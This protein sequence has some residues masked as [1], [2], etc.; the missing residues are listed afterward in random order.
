MVCGVQDGDES[1]SDSRDRAKLTLEW[2]SHEMEGVAC[3]LTS[4]GFA[5]ALPTMRAVGV[6]APRCRWGV[7][8]HV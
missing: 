4:P 5:G 1:K 7:E 6:R 8:C 3:D 2:G